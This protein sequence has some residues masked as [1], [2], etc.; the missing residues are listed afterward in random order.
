MAGVPSTDDAPWPKLPF[1][2]GSELAELG[3]LIDQGKLKV[4][5]DKAYPFSQM[6]E[7]LAHVE[8]GRAKGKVV[9]TMQ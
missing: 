3:A 7:A 4:V 2:L 1:V 9:V 5:I 6:P 8:S